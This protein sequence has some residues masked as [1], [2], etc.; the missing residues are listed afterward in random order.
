[1]TSLS[2][3]VF[4]SVLSSDDASTL[5]ESVHQSA[6][7]KEMK[8]IHNE[9]KEFLRN[10]NNVGWK[11]ELSCSGPFQG[12]VYALVVPN[13]IYIAAI[14]HPEKDGTISEFMESYK[15]AVNIDVKAAHGTAL[16]KVLKR[17]REV[18]SSYNLKPVSEE[19]WMSSTSLNSGVGMTSSRSAE[20]ALETTNPCAK[21]STKIRL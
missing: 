14:R 18:M 7:R 6:T 2:R 5:V 10:R 20:S 19:P 16:G 3:V 13:A 4:L 15:N 8:A 1:M 17:M 9:T 11:G 12:S 21:K